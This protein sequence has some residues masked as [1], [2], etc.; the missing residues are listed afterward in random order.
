MSAIGMP[1]Q[2]RPFVISACGY[3]HAQLVFERQQSL[4]LRGMA[5]EGR[6]KPLMPWSAIIARGAGAL[7]LIVATIALI[8]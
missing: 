4:E 6:L 3:G 7:A 5:W 8:H 2:Q 1:G